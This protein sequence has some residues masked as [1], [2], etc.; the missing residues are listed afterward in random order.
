MEQ[1]CHP[2]NNKRIFLFLNIPKPLRAIE[3]ELGTKMYSCF[4]YIPSV[5]CLNTTV[6]I[7]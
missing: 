1:S 2:F 6:A 7:E 5:R 3:R 4:A